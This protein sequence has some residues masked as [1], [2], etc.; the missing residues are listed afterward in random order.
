MHSSAISTKRVFIRHYSTPGVTVPYCYAHNFNQSDQVRFTFFRTIGYTHAEGE[1]SPA[2]L[3]GVFHS[4]ANKK[5]CVTTLDFSLT[6][7][8]YDNNQTSRPRLRPLPFQTASRP[9]TI[10]I[11]QW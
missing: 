2:L 8:L 1:K 5:A 7:P 10:G 3:P 9:L 4:Q 6:R 11:F